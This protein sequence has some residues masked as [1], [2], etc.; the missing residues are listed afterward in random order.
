MTSTAQA[1]PPTRDYCSA[2]YRIWQDEQWSYRRGWFDGL[3][4]KPYG[5]RQEDDGDWWL[6]E[7]FRL[8][9]WFGWAAAREGRGR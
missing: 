2:Q 5:W 6:N 3:H 8:A 4:G 7:R 9:Y 1:D